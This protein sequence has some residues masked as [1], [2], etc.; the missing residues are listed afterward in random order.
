M[1]CPPVPTQWKKTGFLIC[2]THALSAHVR[3]IVCADLFAVVSGYF[4]STMV[5]G[6]LSWS[7]CMSLI[8]T[9]EAD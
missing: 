5:E 8:R 4:D 3:D 2:S 7:T 1:L 9:G 6:V